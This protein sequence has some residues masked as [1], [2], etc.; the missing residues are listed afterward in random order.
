MDPISTESKEPIFELACEC[1]KLFSEQMLRAK[2]EADINGAK[3]MEEYQQRFA[4]WAAFLGVFAVPEMCLDRRLRR[5]IEIQDLVLRLLDIMKRNLTHLFQ[6]DNTLDRK[7]IKTTNS[8]EPLSH[9]LQISVES[10]SGIEGAVERLNRLGAAIQRS[11]VANQITKVRKF[12]ESFNSTSFEEVAHLAINSI[13]P[14]ANTTLLEQLVR[15]MTEMYEKFCFRQSRQK[16]LQH[17]TR[18]PLSI[19]NEEPASSAE[20]ETSKVSQPLISSTQQD[21]SKPL[22]RPIPRYHSDHISHRSKNS[23]LTSLDSREFEN[24]RR[25][26]K[27][28]SVKSNTRS[29]LVHQIDYPRSSNEGLVC[30]WC[31]CPLLKDEFEGEKWKQ[32]VNKDF[33]PFICISEKCSEPLK[34]FP[35]SRMWFNHMLEVHG[36]NWHREVHLPVHWICPLCNSHDT[37]FS[38]EQDLSDHILEL[39]GKIFPDSQVQIIAGQSR[40]RS[41]HPQDI[42]PLCC[43]SMKDEQESDNK[44]TAAEKSPPKTP[45]EDAEFGDSHK[46]IKTATGH[47]QPVTE[48]TG[49][50]PQ[51]ESFQSQRLSVE[52]IASHVAAH[53]RAILL[54]TLRMISMD[55]VSDILA[56]DQNLPG[57]TDYDSS[58]V[59]SIEQYLEQEIDTI[60]G[61]SVQENDS[62]DMDDYLL[63]DSIPYCDSYIDWQDVLRKNKSSVVSDTFLPETIGS[64]DL[65]ARTPPMPFASIRFSRDPDFVDRGDILNRIDQQCSQL[66]GRVALVGLGGVGKSQLAIEF[67]HRIAARQAKIWVFWIH[68]GTRARVEEGF[69]TIANS[70]KLRGRNQPQ[71]NIPQLVYNWLAN[72]QNGRWFMVLDSADDYDVFYKTS[73]DSPNSQSLATYLPQSQNG[74]IIIT[75]RDRNLGSR[76]TG[77]KPRNLIDVG[78]MTEADALTLL[79]KRLES[80][81]DVGVATN[82]IKALDLIPL[83]ISQAAAYIQAR[84]PRSSL[85][86]YLAEFQ[87]SERKK[88][89][90]LGHDAGDLRRDGGASN[91]ILTTWQISFDYIRSKRLSAAD[92]LS[93]MSFFDPQG[94]PEELLKPSKQTKG[95]TRA[96]S[97]DKTKDLELDGSD[98][99]MSNDSDDSDDFDDG[100]EDDI[101]MLRDYC[102]ITM[103]E[104]GD[105]FK[106]HG[107][108]QLSTRKSLDASGLQ[109]PFK[110]QF[111]ER[112]A[113]AFPTGDYSNW[114]TCQTL[115]AHVEAAVNYRPSDSS[116]E[117]WATLLY[118]GSCYAESQGRYDVAERMAYKSWK[119]RTTKLGPDHLKTISSMAIL[120][121]TYINQGRWNDAEKLGKQV[122]ETRKI[123]LGV[124]HPDTL[125]SMSDLVSIF[126]NQGRWDEA[127]KLGIQVVETHKMKLGADHPDTLISMAN[128]AYTWKSQGR[129]D[130][131]EK[132]G[133]QV[134]E[135]RK[136]KFGVDHPDTLISMA[137]LA[138]TWKA[139]GRHADAMALMKDCVQARQRILGP[140]YPKTLSSIEALEK[141]SR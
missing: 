10:L 93:L 113:A 17:R 13:Y 23:K 101:A 141:W 138:S 9:Q 35:T 123:K 130:E 44:K 19:I 122:M 14:G 127:E 133:I 43:F 21:L 71:A 50:T 49:P 57:G 79:E 53:L 24:M 60:H 82:L 67:V 47:I 95:T 45:L 132:L 90:L 126:C 102:L 7:D 29:I 42:C 64:E 111:I 114:A 89:R 92:L 134:M 108:V 136:M 4:A 26:W 98:C 16:K 34:K 91:A 40:F 25:Q 22:S 1:E 85:D 115:F 15:A 99:D 69:R 32:H 62:M 119:A 121:S 75:T 137:N 124:D 11:L 2:N 116:L 88:F 74:S 33:E 117:S 12:A 109:E 3:V 104:E 59:G 38:R 105:I 107:L 77:N 65:R 125:T 56:D 94:I 36:Q 81:S 41:P 118:N 61:L 8:N 68:A 100:F 131:A 140:E 6:T 73:G 128:L 80:L 46:R 97:P 51:I 20:A 106:M 63:D 96:N 18:T 70:V 31:F 112:L 39:H 55:V 84:A 48:Q 5:H 30:E 37:T 76:L 83:A 52:K 58:R 27:G 54:L 129:W 120:A 139:Q 78:P 135:T 87:E 86:K 66:A 110:Q 28:G 72:E 103:N